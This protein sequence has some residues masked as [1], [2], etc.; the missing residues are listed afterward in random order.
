MQLCCIQYYFINLYIISFMQDIHNS[1]Y[2][3]YSIIYNM[4]KINQAE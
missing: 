3:M 4:S 2:V 1:F